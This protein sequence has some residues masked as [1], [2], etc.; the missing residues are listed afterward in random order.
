MAVRRK[1]DRRHDGHTEDDMNRTGLAHEMKPTPTR[2]TCALSATAQN[3]EGPWWS[4]A[5]QCLYWVDIVGKQVHIFDPAA[6]SNRS[7]TLPELVTSVAPRQN[8]RGLVL[9][10]RNHFAFFDPATGK[11]DLLAEP[12][13]DKPGN[14]FNDGK[15]DRQGRLWA[16]TMG[17]VD[18]DAPVGSLYRFDAARRVVRMDEGICC[19]NG[20]GWS[21]DSSVMYFTESFRHRIFA[22]DFDAASAAIILDPAKANDDR[23]YRA[24]RRLTAGAYTIT[25]D[26]GPRVYLD[27]MSF[28]DIGVWP[29]RLQLPA[30]MALLSPPGTTPTPAQTRD[31][32]N[33]L[34]GIYEGVHIGHAEVRG[35]AVDTPEGPFK[36]AVIRFNLENGKIGEF[37]LEGLDAK[38]PKGP[39]KVGRFALKSFDV[40]NL[41]R[42][43]ARF[44]TPG[45]PPTPDQA[46][47]LLL[48]LEGAEIKDFVAPYKDSTAPVNV[49]N[50]SLDWGQFVGPIPSKA[51]LI[52]KMTAPIDVADPA[53][54]PLVAAGINSAAINVDF[55]AAWTEGARTFALEPVKLELGGVL[56]ASARVS[57]ANVP[58]EV[59]S[60][61]PLQ[62]A[63]MAAQIEAGTVEITLR[64][65]GG[66][67]LLVAQFARTQNL[68]PAAARRAVIE[69]I[70]AN[71][72]AMART[73]PDANAI[74][75]A[76]VAFVENP[77][78]T[79]TV[80]LTPRGKVPAMQLVPALQSNPLAALAWF[81]VEASTGR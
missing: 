7:F 14:R 81:Q 63:V 9:T 77:R 41:L 76:L 47:G 8:G 68:D 10:L 17:D 40:A 70:K 67:D 50:F 51:R 13:P 20:L 46:L 49:E 45:Q 66:V 3:G 30:L 38:S 43:S 65:I 55:G 21:P 52:A 64:D 37:A 19:S 36:L 2:V 1:T 4:A 75:D 71:G 31:L 22:Y 34:A 62:A 12:E 53:L 18:W 61:N 39:V 15:C 29:S 11:L 59:F 28:D 60:T 72:A 58:R 26:K 56:A 27:G 33:K 79:L 54:K 42:M 74:A 69:S 16:G 35:I 48:L 32:L 73:N 6:G 57:L 80:K 44:S 5:E 23:Y 78:G 24:Y 25:S